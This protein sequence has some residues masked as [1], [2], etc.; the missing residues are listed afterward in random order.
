MVD[1]QIVSLIPVT[2]SRLK[3][4]R[5]FISESS[6]HQCDHKNIHSAI[7]IPTVNIVFF[8]ILATS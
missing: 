4:R 2:V 5:I 7:D 1:T 3:H 8:E 6:G